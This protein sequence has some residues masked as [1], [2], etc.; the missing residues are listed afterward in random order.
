MNRKIPIKRSLKFF[1]LNSQSLQ[2]YRE[3]IKTVHKIP[4]GSSQ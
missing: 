4:D 3:L 1:I 2:L